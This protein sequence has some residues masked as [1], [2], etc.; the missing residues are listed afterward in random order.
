MP[1]WWHGS[2]ENTQTASS[3]QDSNSYSNSH[4]LQPQ[5]AKSIS[6][7]TA[8]QTLKETGYSSRMPFLSHNNRKLRLHFCMDSSKLGGGGDQGLLSLSFCCDIWMTVSEI[9]IKSIKIWMQTASYI[10]C[11]WWCKGV[12]N[13]F[14]DALGPL[15]LS[16]HSLHLFASITA[17]KG[18]VG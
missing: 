12:S 16:E 7:Q 3:W 5:E 9:D 18:I 11:W 15:L 1:C 14:L 8:C 17:N 10:I 4:S 2:E 13:I 6:E